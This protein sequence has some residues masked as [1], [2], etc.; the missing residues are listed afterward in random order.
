MGNFMKYC[1]EDTDASIFG[2]KKKKKKERKKEAK[3][4][5]WG[6]VSSFYNA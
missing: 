5:G 3:L 6:N 4:G 1:I 2:K